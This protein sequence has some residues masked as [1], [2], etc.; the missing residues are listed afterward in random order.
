MTSPS[1]GGGGDDA[2]KLTLHCDGLMRAEKKKNQDSRV[3]KKSEVANSTSSRRCPDQRA[4]LAKEGCSDAEEID[5]LLGGWFSRLMW[6][7]ERGQVNLRSENELTLRRC[8]KWAATVGTAQ[9]EHLA[10]L[11]DATMSQTGICGSMPATH[12]LSTSLSSHD[13]CMYR[14]PTGRFLP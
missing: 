12:T 8:G 2:A 11:F 3:K 4:R 1:S 6:S 7:R 10:G 5:G 9:Q 14:L 13:L